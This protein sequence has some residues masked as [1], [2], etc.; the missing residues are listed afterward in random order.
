MV[1]GGFKFEDR[2]LDAG[3]ELGEVDDLRCAGSGDAGGAGDL[4]LVFDL[5]IS[6]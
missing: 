2:F 5:T 6:E 3:G 4:G 1:V